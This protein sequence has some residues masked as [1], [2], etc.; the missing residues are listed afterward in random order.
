[1]AEE[2]RDRDELGKF[3][4]GHKVPSPRQGRLRKEQ[5]FPLLVAVTQEAYSPE[6]IV[7]MIHETYAVARKA[8]DAKAMMQVIQLVLNYA[9][10]KP[11]QRTL[12]ASIDP[13][14]LKELFGGGDD[15]GLGDDGDTV[16][17]EGGVV[18]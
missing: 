10:G 2:R 3:V 7:A 8:D 15:E 11:V 18:E 13:E 6:E 5:R 14:K 12:S 9:I 17:G 1:V 4:K 16:A